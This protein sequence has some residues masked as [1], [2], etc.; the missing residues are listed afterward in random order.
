MSVAVITG[1]AGLIGSEASL[2]FA[3]MGLDIVGIDNDMRRTFFGEEASTLWNRQRVEQRLGRRYRHLDLDIRDRDKIDALFQSLG[4][5]VKVIVH[6]AAQPS[7]DWAARDPHVDFTVNAVGTLNLLEATR[8]HAP[9]AVFIFT[10]TNKV[11]GDLPNQLPLVE[12]E[13]RFEVDPAHA[14]AAGI[15]EEMSIDQSMHS[16]FGA[17]K[18]AADV[19]V[20]EYGR[21]FAL[22]TACFRGGCLTGPNHAGTELHGF[23]SYLMKC[24]MTGA[25]YIV[26]GYKGKQVRDN[27][28]SADLIAAFREFFARPRIGEVY[29]I[30][31]GRFSNCSVLEAIR[32]CEELSGSEIKWVYN[33]RHRSGDHIWWI[34]D[35]SKFQ[36]HYPGWSLQYDVRRILKEICEA[37][38]ERWRPTVGR[39]EVRSG[40][41]VTR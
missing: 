11:Y 29:N 21:Y 17:S 16:V 8:L 18:V 40:E 32:M 28:H 19:M 31:G 10:S 39:F 13:L 6:T 7:H 9:D 2:A 12:R 4:Q 15:P 27:I 24:A 20:Q 36:R 34:S 3:A 38:H 22:R 30:G 26:H 41:P 1:S 5:A 14:Y 33:D 23:L 35:L 37:N 25:P